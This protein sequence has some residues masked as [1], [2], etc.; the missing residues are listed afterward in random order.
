[1][2]G[3]ILCTPFRIVFGAGT[4]MYKIMLAADVPIGVLL[5]GGLDSTL[6][7]GLLHEA[8]HQNIR[9]FSIGFEDIDD[10][11]GSE[12]EYSDQI[13]IINKTPPH[14]APPSAL[15][16]S[17]PPHQVGVILAN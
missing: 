16:Y 4:E 17:P 6:L 1:V 15:P 8:G 3:L 12:F 14:P 13:Q 7:V 9:S 2:A 5:S 11:V 10:E